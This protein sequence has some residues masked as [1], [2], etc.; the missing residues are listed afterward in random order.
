MLA[1]KTFSGLTTLG[2]KEVI[3]GIVSVIGS[4]L[5]A[6]LLSPAEFGLFAILTFAL[7]FLSAFGNVGIGASLVAM[8]TVP[9]LKEYRALFTVEQLM[10]LGVVVLMWILSPALAS[11]YHLADSSVWMFRAISG[12]VWLSS[13]RTASAIQLERKLEIRVIAG[14]EMVGVVTYYGS[15]VARA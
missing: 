6:R 15:A 13:F 8:P 10:A 9:T 12:S 1:Q 5:L 7:G 4:T 11:A 14:V 3:V 2:A